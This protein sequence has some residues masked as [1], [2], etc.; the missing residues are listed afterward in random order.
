MRLLGRNS[1]GQLS[2][3]KDLIGDEI[4]KYAI[5][6]HIWGAEE[7]IFRDLIGMVPVRARLATTRYGSVH[8]RLLTMAYD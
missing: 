6:S 5:L 8:S 3:T 7:V 1:A 2:L 4:P